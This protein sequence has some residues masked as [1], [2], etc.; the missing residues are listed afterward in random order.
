ME[1]GESGCHHT[2]TKERFL[3][4]T[5]EPVQPH[6]ALPLDY[7]VPPGHLRWKWV[8]S[9]PTVAKFLGLANGLLSTDHADNLWVRAR[10]QGAEKLDTPGADDPK[11][12]DADFYPD[13][14]GYKVVLPDGVE[15]RVR[16]K[17]D[18]K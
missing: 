4:A 1:R 10:K 3:V 15:S 6:D 12:K 14:C 18:P 8:P 5:E 16:F 17:R 9:V 11:E 13:T 7:E 2:Q